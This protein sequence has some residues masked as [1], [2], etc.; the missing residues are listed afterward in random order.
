MI[1][2]NT[3][4]VSKREFSTYCVCICDLD[5]LTGCFGIVRVFVWMFFY[6]KL[7]VG[8]LYN[9]NWRVH[10]NSQDLM[11][12]LDVL[13]FVVADIAAV[14]AEKDKSQIDQVE[15]VD[16]LELLDRGSL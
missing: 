3:K 2:Q 10:C 6:R 8:L 1:Y 16:P 4:Y 13:S 15:L 11:R 5:E 12:R 14:P 7:S 9:G